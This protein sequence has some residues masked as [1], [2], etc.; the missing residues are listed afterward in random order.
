MAGIVGTVAAQDVCEV[1]T[2]KGTLDLGIMTQAQFTLRENNLNDVIYTLG[3]CRKSVTTAP[4]GSGQCDNL[5]AYLTSHQKTTGLCDAS[6]PVYTSSQ[7]T[8]D[9]AR[10]GYKIVLSLREMQANR[11]R[12]ELT[13][14][15]NS[16]LPAS[17]VRCANN[18]CAVAYSGYLFQ[19]SFETGAVCYSRFSGSGG[20]CGG[21]CVF[22]IIFFVGGFLYFAIGMAYNY[23]FK[24]LR[25][26]E[27]VPNVEQW[28]ELPVLV[29]DGVV[30][31]YSKISEK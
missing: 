3:W 6:M 4:P 9:N 8:P 10:D 5:P 20:G 31:T 29:K 22:L 26:T 15:C 2:P 30:F 11:Y 17:S 24:E 13:L 19:A 18:E 16:A 21:G 28:K 12:A 27:M 23:R 25:G 14:L 1:N 7:V